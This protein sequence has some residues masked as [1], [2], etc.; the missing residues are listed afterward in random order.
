L[1]LSHVIVTPPLRLWHT[2]RTLES[3]YR[4][5]YNSQ[6][7]DRYAG[8]RDQFHELGRWAYDRL[9]RAGIGITQRPVPRAATPE[10]VPAAGT[11]PDGVYYVTMAWINA[12]GEEGVCATPSPITVSASA[13]AAYPPAAPAIAT[14]WNV[15]AGTGPETLTRQNDAPIAPDA[16]WTQLE[17]TTAGPAPGSG[18]AANYFHAIARV[19]QR[20]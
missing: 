13:F 2:H 8:K 1:D 10:L 18:Q 3:V 15:Y 6:L 14:G 9:L 11:L 17:L 5:A 12:A 19:M 4:D 16:P 20:G 7:N